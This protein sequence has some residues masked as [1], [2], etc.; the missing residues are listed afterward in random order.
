MGRKRLNPLVMH[1]ADYANDGV[2]VQRDWRYDLVCDYLKASPSY[3][4]VRLR[5]PSHKL[6][7]FDAK[8]YRKRGAPSLPSDAAAV[9]RVLQDFGA[10]YKLD[11]VQWWKQIGMQLYGVT[12]PLPE[13]R[14][15][16][17]Q[18]EDD[19]TR[20][21]TWR[22]YGVVIAELPTTLTKA[23]ALKQLQKQLERM[24]FASSVPQA[25]AP[26]YQLY[27]SKLRRDTLQSGLDALRYYERGM[28]LWQIGNRLRLIPA[29]SFNERE[30]NEDNAYLYSEQKELLSIAARRLIR[31]AVLVAENA[32][33][34]RFPC[35][36]PFAEA[37]MEYYK[38]KPG[39]PVGSTRAKRRKA[40]A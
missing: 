14:C 35:D 2:S 21:R 37:Q 11:E 34:G 23:Q 5:L 38:R 25:I 39:R 33:R 13:V 22:G 17:V 19:A 30:V 28:P 15:E 1:G 16:L 7:S 27:P 4:A 10:I 9:K 24:P 26:K 8:R 12:A 18:S 32:A 29:Q 31:T 36:K 6:P 20:N 40:G 3:E